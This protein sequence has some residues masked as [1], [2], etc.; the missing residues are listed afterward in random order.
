MDASKQISLNSRENTNIYIINTNIYVYNSKYIPSKVV[1]TP[2]RGPAGASKEPKP[3]S[4][5]IIFIEYIYRLVLYSLIYLS[6]EL[7]SFCMVFHLVF[8]LAK[9]LHGFPSSN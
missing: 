9:L 5:I 2:N 8:L 4:Q 1:F 7:I 3:K 6:M